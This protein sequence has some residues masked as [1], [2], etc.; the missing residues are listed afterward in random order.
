MY[1]IYTHMYYIYSCIFIYN[2]KGNILIY[3][4]ILEYIYSIYTYIHSKR[5]NIYT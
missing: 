4:N 2:V 1:M 3:K 5:K